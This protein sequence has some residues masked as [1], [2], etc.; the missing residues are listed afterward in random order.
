M[1]ETT[2]TSLT[3]TLGDVI[4]EAKM[5]NMVANDQAVDAHAQGIRFDERSD[6]ADEDVSA[7]E[8]FLYAKNDGGA[9]SLFAKTDNDNVFE[10]GHKVVEITLVDDTTDNVIGDKTG[11]IYL[12]IPEELDG[13]NLVNAHASVFTAGTTGTQDIQIH[14]VDNGGVDMLSPKITIDSGETSSYTAATSPAINTSND[15]VSKGDRIR[16]DVDAI[17]TGTAAKGLSVILTFQIP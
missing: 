9:S 7:G 2:Y 4:T 16:V 15:D 14:N 3:W 10:I 6:P 11:D 8:M 12:V 5:D 17:H 13:W 1:A